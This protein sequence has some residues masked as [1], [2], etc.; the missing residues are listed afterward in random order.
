MNKIR[1]IL[2]A[3]VCIA[4][5]L[6]IVPCITVG[7]A[8][9][10]ASGECGD[11]LTWTLDNDG[12]LAISGTGEMWD[13]SEYS[14][15][16]WYENRK[17]IT[18]A[19][20]EDGVT[21]I[22][23]YAF[24]GCTGLISVTIP[25][26]IT[27]IGDS[28]F[29]YCI[30]LTSVNIPDSVTAIG[31]HVFHGCTSL[32][33][34]TI[35]DSVTVI[36]EWAFYGCTGLTSITIP[37]SVTA[38]GEYAFDSCTGL[39]SVT[40]PASV[41]TIG[42]GAFYY[43]TGLTSVSISASV[44]TIG[45]WAFVECNGLTS[46][47][48]DRANPSYT[49]VGGVLFDKEITELIQY[50]ANKADTEYTI[51]S[52]V[53][54]I[55]WDA[56]YGCESLTSVTIPDSV[57]VIGEWAFYGCDYLTDVYYSGSE[58]EWNVIS[59]SDKNDCL[60]NAT[61]HYSSTDLEPAIVDVE[62]IFKTDEATGAEVIVV[63]VETEIVSSNSALLAVG[64]GDSGII[65]VSSVKNGEAALPA[66]GVKTVKVFCWESLESMKPLCEAKEITVQ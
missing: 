3:L 18:S 64:I 51:P 26:S 25:A 36:D 6:A 4:M 13:W 60:T 30:G 2:A 56:F 57:T 65:S 11:N 29:E 22:G 27:T 44:T 46:I 15:A 58:E 1:M 43:C 21:N 48:V 20:I 7:A 66:E 10:V 33:S 39:I 34:I 62:Y 17:A 14:S 59:I 40:I 55:G 5:T 50:P 45:A 35:P 42:S 24:C 49:S 28:A 37:D 16:P 52:G 9:I 41:T 61:I 63:T 47:E 32:T 23:E 54:T 38:I 8:E 12:V 31:E 19:I 53:T